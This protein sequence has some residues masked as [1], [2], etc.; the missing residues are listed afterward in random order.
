MDLGVDPGLSVISA[1]T[2]NRRFGGR[3]V[4]DSREVVVGRSWIRLEFLA[5]IQRT[6]MGLLEGKRG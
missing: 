4:R 3:V 1:R 5:L 6:R 2:P